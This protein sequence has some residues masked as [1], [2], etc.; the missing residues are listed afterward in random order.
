[1]RQSILENA[2]SLDPQFLALRAASDRVHD[3]K[4]IRA[5]ERGNFLQFQTGQ[6]A[7]RIA[8][9]ENSTP[10]DG[11]GDGILEVRPPPARSDVQNLCQATLMIEGDVRQTRR[12]QAVVKR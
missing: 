12:V 6:D 4:I 2:F 7:L 1:M 11:V 3:H 10:R 5:I 9:V 8:S